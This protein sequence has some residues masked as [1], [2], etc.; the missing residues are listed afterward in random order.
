MDTITAIATPVGQSAIGII[1][2]SGPA[3][4][5]I[6]QRIYK[7]KNKD[8]KLESIPTHTIHYGHI[9]D[10]L[11]K[12]KIDEVLVSVMRKPYSYTREDVVEINCHGGKVCL[13]KVLEL[14]LQQGA[15]I[16][17]PGEFTKRAFLNGRIDLTQAESI[18]DIINV[19]SEQGLSLMLNTLEGSAFQPLY[20]LHKEINK[21]Q[22]LIETELNFSGDVTLRFS[23]KELVDDI[24]RWSQVINTYIANYKNSNVLVNGLQMAIVGKTNVGKSSIMNRLLNKNRSIVTDLPG[25]TTDIVEDKFSFDGIIIRL[26]D[27]AGI[28]QSRNKIE[29]E[30]ILRTRQIIGQADLNMVVFDGSQDLNDYDRSIF[31]LVCQHKK[32]FFIVLNKMDL[33]DH[34]SSLSFLKYSK[35]QVPILK[36]CALTGKGINKIPQAISMLCVPDQKDSL[37]IGINLRQKNI[38]LHL[39]R[40]FLALKKS[41]KR[42]H[43]EEFLAEDFRDLNKSFNQFFGRHASE[44]L[45]DQIFTKFCIGK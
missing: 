38:L 7:S 17:E 35:E 24:N 11:S 22:T 14:I 19:Q 23:N 15:R 32:P 37:T 5:E 40:S 28:C 16:A 20:D 33:G 10:P 42:E 27:T 6:T 25:T 12:K 36:I 8:K 2:L 4:I 41:I 9:I 13:Y 34:L 18:I 3:A 30:G 29:E 43:C 45:L 21:W 39:K 44:D 26:L 31:D 1:K